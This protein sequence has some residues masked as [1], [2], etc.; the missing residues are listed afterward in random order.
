MWD[1]RLLC[2]W[3]MMSGITIVV[4]ERDVVPEGTMGF[5]EERHWREVD[6]G[7]PGLECQELIVKERENSHL[8]SQFGQISLRT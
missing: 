2:H 6:I 7:V 5:A 8:K 3:I 1:E 4:N